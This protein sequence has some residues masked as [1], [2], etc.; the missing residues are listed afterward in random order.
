MS[1]Y[2]L[3]SQLINN[4]LFDLY[5]SYVNSL[6]CYNNLTEYGYTFP[7]YLIP[8]LTLPILQIF[9]N[10]EFKECERI[11]D[12]NRKRSGRIK[13]KITEMIKKPCL[14]L[15]LTFTDETLTNTSAETR[16]RYVRQ[17]LTQFNV[18]AI[19]NKDFGS[20]NGREHYHSIIQ[21]SNIDYSLY[22]YGA[23]NGKRV[24]VDYG[25][26][27]RISKYISKLTNHSIKETT[28]RSTLIYLHMNKLKIE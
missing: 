18:P 12:S 3:K 28:K 13:K 6:N 24:I 14:F 23:I 16:R 8:Y 26:D 11:Y 9:T 1:D 4:G 10:E 19:A 27:K 25:C 20:E 15:T 22:T 21:T 17:F 7:D 2:I 5:K